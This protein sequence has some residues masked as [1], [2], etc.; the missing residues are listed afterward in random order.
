M[1]FESPAHNSALHFEEETKQGGKHSKDTRIK[2][3]SC[4]I[5]LLFG[6]GLAT[7]LLSAAATSLDVLKLRERIGMR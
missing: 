7:H 5:I 2:S 6:G 3:C 1:I 4:T